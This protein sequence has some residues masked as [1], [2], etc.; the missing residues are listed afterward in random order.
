MNAA[1]YKFQVLSPVFAVHWHLQTY[2]GDYNPWRK[3]QVNRNAHQ[4]ATFK[5]EIQ[6]R[7]S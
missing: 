5:N 7:Y 6:A 1:G 4:L 3:E 2:K